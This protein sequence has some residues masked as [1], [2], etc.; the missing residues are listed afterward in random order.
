MQPQAPAQ[1]ACRARAGVIVRRGPEAAET[2][3]DVSGG[4]RAPERCGDEL[5]LVAEIFAPGELQPPRP[6]G[7]DELR[8]VLVLPLP[9]QDFIADDERPEF[10]SESS[11]FK[12]SGSKFS[13]RVNPQS[14]TEL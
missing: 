11:K 4:E 5:G 1:R 8:H 10:H 3:H 7:L 2:E 14:G 6:E 13:G 9:G 12:G